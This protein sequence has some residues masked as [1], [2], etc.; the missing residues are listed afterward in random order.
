MVHGW[1]VL[2]CVEGFLGFMDEWS[3][4]MLRYFKIYGMGRV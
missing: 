2:K 4:G 1:L 3:L